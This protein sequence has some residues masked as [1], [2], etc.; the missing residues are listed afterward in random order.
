MDTILK[1][2]IAVTVIV[3]AIIGVAVFW[4]QPAV[5]P[6]SKSIDVS[7]ISTAGQAL[8]GQANAPVTMVYWSDYQCPACKM[9]DEESI[10]HIMEDYVAD[11]KVKILFKDFAF[12]GEDSITAAMAGQ[13]IWQIA[14][15]KF[16]QWH[17][18]VFEKQGE[19]NKGWAAREKLL[20]IAKSIGIDDAKVGQ[21]MDQNKVQYQKV[22][23]DNLAEGT[24]LGI[25]S[26]PTFAINGQNMVNGVLP[27]SQVKQLIEKALLK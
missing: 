17:E 18:A 7:K 22:I 14:P 11:G 21:L 23:D 26:T 19:E 10:S 3:L 15:D 27:Y 9:F 16:Y 20:A 6:A 12:I 25:R 1:W 24:T 5:V 2:I 13:A 8:L 4:S